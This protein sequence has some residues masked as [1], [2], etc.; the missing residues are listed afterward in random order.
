MKKTMLISGILCLIAFN[1]FAQENAIKINPL[2][3]ILA[4]GNISYER[5]VGDKQSFQLGGY[6]TG[7]K[8]SSTKI[9]GYGVTPEYRFYLGKEALNSFYAAPYMR[10]QSISFK[11]TEFD[12]KATLSTFGGGLVIGRQWL[13]GE[14]FTIDLFL[15]PNYSSGSV[16]VSFGDEDDFKGLNF[17]T[18]FGLRSGITLGLAF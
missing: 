9:T 15:G 11:E 12:S 1:L 7:V 2:S 14:S 17:F 18:G 3:A 4:T 6:Y 10:Y 16:K 5:V 13:I 8:F